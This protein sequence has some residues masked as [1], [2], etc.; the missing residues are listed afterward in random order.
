MQLPKGK[1]GFP[2]PQQ[3][4]ALNNVTAKKLQLNPGFIICFLHYQKQKNPDHIDFNGKIRKVSECSTS[5]NVLTLLVCD[6]PFYSIQMC[7][8]HRAL[9]AF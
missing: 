5:N 7:K 8:Q 9:P 6:V 1:D 4:H 3:K 2:P